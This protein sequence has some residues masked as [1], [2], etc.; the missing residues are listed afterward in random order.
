MRFFILTTT[1]RVGWF[2]FDIKINALDEKKN[3]LILGKAA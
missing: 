2:W 3:I 1:N